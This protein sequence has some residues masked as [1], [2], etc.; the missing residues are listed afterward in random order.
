MIPYIFPKHKF[1]PFTKGK[2]VHQRSFPLTS[3]L[4]K[5]IFKILF[6]FVLRFKETMTRLWATYVV[7]RG[8]AFVYCSK[9][10][11]T[12]SKKIK[13]RFSCLSLLTP[14]IHFAF[15][16]HRQLVV[17]IPRLSAPFCHLYG[18]LNAIVPF[19]TFRYWSAI[20]NVNTYV[21]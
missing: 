4:T 5:M 15:R 21:R 7:C 8:I 6:N 18:N 14:S 16:Y 1:W 13:H 11:S 2:L 19:C 10:I 9:C 12:K 17:S 20:W 3:P